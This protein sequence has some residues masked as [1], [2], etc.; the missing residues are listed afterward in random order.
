MELSR[1][2]VL[3]LVGGGVLAAAL[4]GCDGWSVPDSA[5]TAWRNAG[6]ETD[7]RRLALSYSLLAPSAHNR[8]SWLVDLR[9]PDQ[10]SLLVD[11]RR[12]LPQT[13]PPGRQVTISQGT[14]LE[15]LDMA[16]RQA[17]VRPAVDLF[18]EGEYGSVPDE[19]PVARLR[20]ERPAAVEPDAL[21]AFVA[22]RHTNRNGFDTGSEVAPA[23]LE[24]IVRARVPTG[25]SVGGTLEP[26]LRQR[27]RDLAQRAFEI[28]VSTPRTW[29]ETV[30]LLRVGAREIAANRDG[31]AV[32]GFLPWFGSI[33]GKTTVERMMDPAGTAARSAFASARAQAQSAMGWVWL[34]TDGNSRREQVAAGR[35]YVRL[36]L[37]AVR[38]GLAWHPM[39]QLLQEYAEMASMQRAL[40]AALGLDPS[41]STLQMLARI[42][43]A[44]AAE[45]A[46]R[47]EINS[48][49]RR[50]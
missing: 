6:S 45:A 49:I 31:L 29:R 46:P 4:P 43:F 11:T 10:I 39:S 27:L 7:L 14:F 8:Q 2:T 24:A 16:L 44:P 23:A 26:A 37:E 18:P 42:G 20:L 30:E 48:L 25:V 3:R 34:A 50:A 5:T 32:T 15:V 47:R 9:H 28:E 35:A 13:D 36:H 1:R 38:L 17:G 41:V 33:L 22:R 19:R 40:Y 21:F 12:L